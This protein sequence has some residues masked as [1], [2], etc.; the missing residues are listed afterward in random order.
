MQWAVAY[1]AFAFALLQGIDI[2]AHQFGWSDNVQRGCTLALIVGFVVTLVLAWYHGEQGRQRV[3]GPELL[4]IALALAIG[5][6]FLW[7]FSRS[8]V[9][10]E[11]ASATPAAA[12]AGRDS[13]APVTMPASNA[14]IPAKSIAVLPFENLSSDKDNA[15]FADGM[16]DLILT[17]LADIGDLKV[18]SRTSTLKYKS[19]PENLKQVAAELG[20]ATLLEGSVQKAGD[21]VLINVQLIDARSD[22]HLWASTYQRTLDNIFGV[23]SEVAGKIADA[24]KARLSPT[25]TARLA[26][27]LSH[28][29][30]A[31]DL[32]FKAEYQFRQAEIN[33]G[34]ASVKAAIPLYRQAIA[35]APDFALAYARLSYAE[36]IL[37]WWGGG[38]MDVKSL[39]AAARRD[40][41]QAFKLAPT[42]AAAQLALGYSDMYGRNDYAGALKTFVAAVTLKPND[43]DALAARG[44]AERRL[45]RFK[46]AIDSL[47]KASTLDPRNATQAFHL[48]LTWMMINRYPEAERALRRALILDPHSLI[49][50]VYLSSAYLL[51]NGDMS[52]GAGRSARRGR[53]T[54][55][56]ARVPADPAASLPGGAGTAGWHSRHAGELRGRRLQ[57]A[58]AGRTVPADG[59]IGTGAAT[60]RAGAAENACTT[61][62]AARSCQGGRMAEPCLCRAWSWPHGQGAECDRQF[63]DPDTRQSQPYGGYRSPAIRRGALRRGTASRPGGAVACQGARQSRRRLVVLAGH[64]VDRPG[65]GPDP[66]GSGLPGAAGQ[67]RRPQAGL[68]QRS[69]RA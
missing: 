31:N 56:A 55:A 62:A 49:S 52:A 36:S 11:K 18:I 38:G 1:V 24:L 54:E 43:A 59:R 67:V 7:Q 65:L 12:S 47:Q 17:K 68:S 33:F 35:Q 8:P 3:T 29:S 41:E 26:S 50:K 20:V 13:A 48:G 5:G 25:D 42:L 40:A 34:T 46:A 32:F 45:G 21:Q 14:S 16:Q 15:Y 51:A 66:Q 27:D 64:V 44:W 58:A 23:E 60:V 6:G 53:D 61:R 2:V 19:R 37:A 28:D 63:P 22:A 39:I 4:L 69:D 10:D 30:T 9:P 57:G